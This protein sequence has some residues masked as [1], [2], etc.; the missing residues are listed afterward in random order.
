MNVGIYF[1]MRSPVRSGADPARLY[2]F[3]LE[4]C[5]EADSLG[6][7]SVW[8][9]EHHLFSD[10]YLPQPLTMAAAVPARTRRCRIGTA[11]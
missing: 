4:M 10:G 1:D 7:H 11:S 8:L 3:V 5:E 9:S 2:G 6:C